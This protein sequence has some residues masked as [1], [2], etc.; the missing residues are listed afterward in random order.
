[1]SAGGGKI[2]RETEGHHQRRR[3]YRRGVQ[4]CRMGRRQR[5]WCR[6]RVRVQNGE[7]KEKVV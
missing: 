6:R 3:W 5:R 4:G 7:K 1:V 2:V